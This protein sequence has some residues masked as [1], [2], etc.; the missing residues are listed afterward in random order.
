MDDHI[1]RLA[2]CQGH[3][4]LRRQLISAGYSDN[5]LYR[6][7]QRGELVQIRR[8]A[9]AE[10]KVW[11]VLDQLERHQALVRAVLLQIKA[12]AVPSHVSAAVVLGLRLW[13]A[14]LSIVHVTRTDLHSTRL[15]GGVM[16]HAGS[17]PPSDLITTADGVTVTSPLRTAVDIARTTG[18]EAAVVVADA[19]LARPESSHD[20]LL[21]TLD[22]MRDWPGARAAGRVVEFANGLSESVGESRAR[23]QF[24]RIGLP[25]PTLQVPVVVAGVGEDRVDFL[26]EEERTVVEFD[27]RV[28]YGR[29]LAPGVDPGDVVWREKL[30]EDRIRE[31]GFGFA[32]MVWADLYRDDVLRKRLRLAFDRARRPL[33]AAGVP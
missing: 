27:G 26:F 4:V 24:E 15:E 3:V 7:R 25:R 14:D 31:Q 30:R 32:R 18:F 29:L 1:S 22:R 20:L 10:T 2:A 13:E 17:L 23:V 16:H 12:P 19:A 5:E 21:G 9:Y 6:L 33:A 8:G 28:K 11:D